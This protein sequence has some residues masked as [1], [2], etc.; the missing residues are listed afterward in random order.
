MKRPVLPF[1]VL[2]VLLLSIDGSNSNA[3]R[4]QASG[5]SGT[6]TQ[7]GLTGG[8]RSIA[9][10]GHTNTTTAQPEDGPITLT[11]SGWSS[12]PAED[13]LVQQNLS[14]FQARHPNIKVEW[15]PIPLT[16][17]YLSRL[18]ADY[19]NGIVPDVFYMRPD[20]APD[21]IAAGKLLNL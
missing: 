9:C 15:V 4:A 16:G 10:P 1:L 11:V 20:L 8:N 14:I 6:N 18:A 21:Y 5:D 2:L 17:D 7:Q 13:A 19:E 3:G 12:T